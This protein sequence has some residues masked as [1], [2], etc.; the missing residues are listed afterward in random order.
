MAERTSAAEP[1]DPRRDAGHREEFEVAAARLPERFALTIR[2]S[3]RGLNTR[4]VRTAI[5]ADLAVAP[6]HFSADAPTKHS[7]RTAARESH[8]A[9][10]RLLRCRQ[11]ET[12]GVE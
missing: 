3:L 11:K 4:E 2:H 8:W 6:E 5:C 7:A 9:G 12:S 10:T 1:I